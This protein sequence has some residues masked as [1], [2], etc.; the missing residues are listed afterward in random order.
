MNITMRIELTLGRRV[1][2]MRVRM[3]WGAWLARAL[4]VGY[5]AWG[6][7]SVGF[8]APDVALILIGLIFVAFPEVMGVILQL[9]AR[10]FGPVYTYTLTDETLGVTTRVTNV[11]VKWE[12]L[13]SLRESRTAWRLRFGGGIGME[14]PKDHFSPEQDAEWRAFASSRGLVRTGPETR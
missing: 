3:G 7:L 4:G 1:R 10:K 6:I 8:G 14:L 11:E 2:N 5:L 9:T 13:K 12:S